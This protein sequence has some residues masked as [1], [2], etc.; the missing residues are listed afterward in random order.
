MQTTLM[1]IQV[2]VSILLSVA[3]LTQNKGSGLGATFGGT[4]EF[5]ASKRGA[6]KFLHNATIVLALIFLVNSVA[7]LFV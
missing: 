4:G 6:E 5:Y 2:I 3:I 1:V 7:F